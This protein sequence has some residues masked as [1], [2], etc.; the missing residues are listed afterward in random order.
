MARG[1]KNPQKSI[2]RTWP[3]PPSEPATALLALV[4]IP[5]IHRSVAC[6]TAVSGLLPAS[7]RLFHRSI[8]RPYNVTHRSSSSN[9]HLC[10]KKTKSDQQSDQR[11]VRETV[12]WD[13]PRRLRLFHLVGIL[14]WLAA[15]NIDMESVSASWPSQALSISWYRYVI[16]SSAVC[17]DSGFAVL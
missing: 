16:S 12:T 14:L 10:G 8:S 9:S 7:A 4:L 3:S 2:E 13:F 17:S 15:G 5:P 1:G 6:A 11:D